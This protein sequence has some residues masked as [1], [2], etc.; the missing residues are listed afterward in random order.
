MEKPLTQNIR[1]DAPPFDLVQYEQAGGYEALRAAVKLTPHEVQEKVTRSG[2][3][4]QGGAGFPTGQKWSYVPMGPD[5]P[6]PRYFVVNAD[7]MEPGTFKDRMLLE[8]DPH[9]LIEGAMICGLE[10]EAEA[11]YIFLRGEY[12]L[13][14]ARLRR[15]I[16]E[17]REKNYI[18]K[19]ILGSSRGCELHLHTS[20][21]RYMCGEETGLIN[22]LEG[23][24]ANPRNKPPH[25]VAMGL[26]GR[27]TVV[28]NVETVC[29]IRHIV[30]RG[31]EWFKSLAR[32]PDG[33][34]TKIYGASGRVKRPGLWELPMGTPLREI[35]F[36]HAGGMRD[37]YRLRGMLPGGASTEF[38]LEEH[39]DVPMDFKSL[40]KVGS[41]L[42]TGSV[43]VLDDR[44]CPVG[45]VWNLMHFFARESCGW[46]T[47]CREG[48][49]WAAH[50]LAA[51]EQGLGQETDL[52][53]L[54]HLTHSLGP[55][56]TFCALA[57]GAIEP[58]A[59]ALK[60]FHTDFLHHI[61]QRHCPWKRT[62]SVSAG[63]VNEP[64]ALARGH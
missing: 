56:R 32:S 26:F 11:V 6:R 45:M 18:G 5:A 51:I 49:P 22:A 53:V 7:E 58:L 41:R 61:R 63:S 27:P 44:T 54:E 24:R 60:Y 34:G 29:S 57:P 48:L 13:A 36:E 55:G 9:Q 30:S 38:L 12:K 14:E 37:G 2:L 50:T 33:A 31:P 46:C 35:L 39:L 15:A 17:A 40:P 16:A 42:G 4:G 47:P 64:Q 25:P 43:V 52:A 3:R 19:N 20:A 59:S 62:P 23:R 21:G 10:I 8:G 1:P 28:N